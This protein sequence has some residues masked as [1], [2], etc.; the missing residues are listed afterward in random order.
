MNEHDDEAWLDSLLRRQGL[1]GL[2]ESGFPQRVLRALPPR[3]RKGRRALV[4][5]LSGGVALGALLLPAVV[6]GAGV[7]ASMHTG[8]LLVPCS[9]AT[10][11]LWYVV[12][13]LL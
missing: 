8:S 2:P 6:G 12:D 7:T 5:G 1:P 3:E 13:L 11:L 4:L 9:L 10:A